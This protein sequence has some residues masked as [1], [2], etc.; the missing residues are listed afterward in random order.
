MRHEIFYIPIRGMTLEAKARWEDG[1]LTGLGLRMSEKRLDN[2]VSGK[3]S[4]SSNGLREDVIAVLAGAGFVGRIPAMAKGTLFQIRV[5]AA[6]LDVP[7]GTVTTYS[8][9]ARR[10]GC[11][12]SRAVGQAL[13]ANPLPVLIPCHRVVCKAGGLGGYS[14]G[15]DIKRLILMHEGGERR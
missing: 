15:L 1:Y 10:I 14:C 6:L 2:A 13:K 12:S 9:L 8:G 7:Y 5:W 3:I 4:P 11:G